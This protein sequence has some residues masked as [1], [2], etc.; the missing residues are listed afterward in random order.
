M[1]HHGRLARFFVVA[2]A[3][4]VFKTGFFYVALAHSEIH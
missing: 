3:V 4:V 2:A 1:C